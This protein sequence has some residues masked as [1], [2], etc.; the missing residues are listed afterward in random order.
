MVTKEDV[1]ELIQKVFD[2]TEVHGPVVGLIHMKTFV[3]PDKDNVEEANC[4]TIFFSDGY[5]F[6]TDIL[7]IGISKNNSGKYIE[8]DLLGVYAAKKIIQCIPFIGEKVEGDFLVNLCT[9]ENLKGQFGKQ[10]FEDEVTFCQV[11]RPIE[12]G[13]IDYKLNMGIW[14]LDACVQAI[15]L[16]EKRIVKFISEYTEGDK[17]V[18]N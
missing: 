11:F 3:F 16:N 6:D 8:S 4:S 14:Y 2:N 17:N 10:N 5:C 7:S 13:T 9:Y 12:D 15:S 1:K 18:Q